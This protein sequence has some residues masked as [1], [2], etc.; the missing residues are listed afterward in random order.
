[1]SVR[2]AF[3]KAVSTVL[4]AVILTASVFAEL[5][6]EPPY[7]DTPQVG[8]TLSTTDENDDL[9]P[10]V[11]MFELPRGNAVL[12]DEAFGLD[13]LRGIGR[14]FL[15]VQTRNG[16]TFYIIVETEIANGVQTVH[17]L[18]AV[19]D[20]DLFEFAENFPADFVEVMY[21]ERRRNREG[22]NQ[23]R[24]NLGLE[25]N[26]EEIP[27][28]E[29]VVTQSVNVETPVVPRQRSN[30]N[31]LI[32]GAIIVFAIAVAIIL[33]LRKS[34]GGKNNIPDEDDESDDSD[35]DE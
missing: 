10:N 6:T 17:F 11:L 5:Y 7:S 21:A 13:T 20:W 23:A 26:T 2:K 29:P 28:P 25:P 16:N 34:G 27:L 1:M 4:F 18:N 22:Y 35:D 9:I 3:I 32:I 24:E 33:K 30:N 8:E 14:Q 15:T 19:D 31:L 12:L